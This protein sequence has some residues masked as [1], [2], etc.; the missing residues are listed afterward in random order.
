MYVLV[1]NAG[2]PLEDLY[3]SQAVNREEPIEARRR[4]LL[5]D[6]P[7]PQRYL[8]WLQGVAGCVVP[9]AGCDLGVNRSGQPVDTLLGQ[10]LTST[11]QLV[12]TAAVLAIILGITV[13]I[14]TALRQYSG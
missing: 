14:I 2:D 11:L 10:A 1:A 4:A 9:L 5:L 3:G 6:V 13:G 8:Q 12:L 7:V